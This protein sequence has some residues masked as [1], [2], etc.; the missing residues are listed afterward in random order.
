MQNLIRMA[1]LAGFT[2][3]E[4]S[5]GS[6]LPNDPKLSSGAALERWLRKEKRSVSDAQELALFAAYM[7]AWDGEKTQAEEWDRVLAI[8]RVLRRCAPDV[9]KAEKAAVKVHK[10]ESY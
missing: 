3:G 6:S 7:V 1:F 4:E 5:E 9:L 10:R 8:A 2:A